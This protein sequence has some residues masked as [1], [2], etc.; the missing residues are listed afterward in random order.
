MPAFIV[1]QIV[2]KFLQQNSSIKNASALLLG[3]TFKEN[4]PDLRNS[5]VVD[6]YRELNEF[7]FEVDVYDPEADQTVFL[8]EYSKNKLAKIEKKYEVIILAVAHEEFRTINPKS[9]LQENGIVFDIKGFYSD[10]DFHYL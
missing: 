6:V 9:L 4:C 10:P 8:K 1:N 5:K 7:G 2:K 3:A